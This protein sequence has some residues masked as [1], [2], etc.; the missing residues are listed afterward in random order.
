MQQA[1]AFEEKKKDP[2][3]TKSRRTQNTPRNPQQTGDRDHLET[4]CDKTRLTR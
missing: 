4:A 3:P 1:F 2:P